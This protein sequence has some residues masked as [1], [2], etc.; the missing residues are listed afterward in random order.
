[1]NDSSEEGQKLKKHCGWV[2][3]QKML[4]RSGQDAMT[5]E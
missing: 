3:G 4:G 1:M 5:E 2:R